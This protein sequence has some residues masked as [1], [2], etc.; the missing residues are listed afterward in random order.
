MSDPAEI[1]ADFKRQ[2][3]KAVS[4]TN[5]IQYK[6]KKP[7]D[8]FLVSFEAC[9]EIKKVYEI[10]SVLNTIVKIEPTKRSKLIPQ[11]KV[12]QSFGHTQNYC[13]KPARCVKC[14][15]KHKTIDCLKTE[16]EQP[17]CVNCGEAHPANY[18]GCVVAKELQKLR[19]QKMANV[20]P[21][22]KR[23]KTSNK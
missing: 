1:I 6:T 10:R 13:G 21:P 8:I 5:K 23:W 9:E 14:A 15:G 18:R 2:N 22:P 11:C 3:L 17:K 20:H 12:C 4:A 7:L 16:T 19:N